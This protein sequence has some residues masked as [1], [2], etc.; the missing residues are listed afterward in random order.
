MAGIEPDYCLSMFVLAGPD[1]YTSADLEAVI[2]AFDGIEL[3]QVLVEGVGRE[4]TLA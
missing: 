1:G 2:I 4:F 3:R